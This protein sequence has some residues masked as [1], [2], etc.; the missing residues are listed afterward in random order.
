MCVC[1]MFWPEGMRTIPPLIVEFFNALGACGRNVLT[2]RL[3]RGPTKRL[4]GLLAVP[5]FRQLYKEELGLCG[6]RVA[7]QR[8]RI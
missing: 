6:Y 2:C 1:V 7:Q 3:W 5:S 4:S 8:E